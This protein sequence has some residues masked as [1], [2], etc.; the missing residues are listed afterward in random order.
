MR[1]LRSFPLLGVL[2]ATAGCGDSS[3]GPV[4][5]A[6]SAVNGAGFAPVYPGDTARW[7]G[8]GFGAEQGSGTVLVT[9][10][11]GLAAASVIAWRDAE[12]QAIL[13][14][15]LRTGSTYVV[16]A[17]DT[18]GP[19]DLFV[20]PRAAYDPAAHAWTGDASLPMP[21]AGAA[22][23]VL[24]YPAAAGLSSL[25]VL[26]GGRGPDSS[27][28]RG[29]YIGL[30]GPDGRITEWHEAPDTIIPP[31]RWLHGGAGGDRTT[32]VLDGVEGVAYILGG[33]DSAGRVLT[34]ALG[35]GL[36]SDGSYGLWTTLAP[37]P[38]RRAGIA[39][40]TAFS[41]VYAIGGF[42]SDSLATRTVIYATVLPS[43]TLNGW[44]RGPE[45]PEGRAFGVAAVAGSTLLVLGG[46][47]GLIDPS[48]VADSAQLAATVYA[49]RLSPL[50]GAFRDSAWT[51]L[52]TTLLRPR[53]RGSAFVVDDALVVTGGVYVGMPSAGETEFAL[54]SG[55][56][57]GTFH[58]SPASSLA[59][60]AGGPVWL[61]AG[62][63]LWDAAGSA[64]VTLVG[65]LITDTPTTRVWS[66]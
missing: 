49:I 36:A 47:R 66:Q 19:L 17:A 20:R 4:T 10:S 30:V 15:D 11:S 27:L 59:A 23:S 60:L 63:L 3:E 50:T 55:G 6:L 28:S 45:L 52:P 25:V 48:G 41:K 44:F 51:E 40:V 26:H 31:G 35:L 22:A 46:E 24:R 16:T 2:L 32:A 57:P 5:A 38:E 64:R 37:L 18:L 13:P 29:T 12:V 7:A 42:G 43:G 65:G 56:I 8:F 34:D 14:D 54:L 1:A 61:A 21:V 62:P 39:A 33:I 53:S 58:E 9:T